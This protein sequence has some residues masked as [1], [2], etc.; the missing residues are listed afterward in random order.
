MSRICQEFAGKHYSIDIVHLREERKRAMHDGVI[1]TPAVFLERADGRKQKLGNLKD[2]R[3]Y[4]QL[5][6]SAELRP[7]AS[8]ASPDKAVGLWG[9]RLV[10]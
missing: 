3:K 10:C 9:F 7:A 8:T 5:M 6:H 1:S 2:A 4:L